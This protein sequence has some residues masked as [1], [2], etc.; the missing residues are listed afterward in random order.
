MLERH[1]GVTRADWLALAFL[2]GV[3]AFAFAGTRGLWEPAEGWTAREA[4][5]TTR[6]GAPVPGGE[7]ALGRGDSGAGGP[8]QQAHCDRS[9]Q[10]HG[11]PHQAHG[12][13]NGDQAHRQ[14]DRPHGL[15]LTP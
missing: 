15:R 2:A 4:E 10:A 9:Q 5:R 7:M 3:L 11:D 6:S 14:E 13:E 1:R 12:N 8:A